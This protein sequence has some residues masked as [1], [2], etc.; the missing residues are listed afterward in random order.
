MAGPSWGKI[1]GVRIELGEIESAL[2]SLPGVREAVVVVREDVP[3]DRR[4]V[5]YVVAD[6]PVDAP[7]EKLRR[8]L[9]ERLPDAMVPSAFV[10]LAALP[11]FFGQQECRDAL[12]CLRVRRGSIGGKKRNAANGRTSGW[13]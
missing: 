6:A 8:S 11:A 9:R 3:G 2:G 5:A 12:A 4:L 7:V 1:R 13:Q 10:T